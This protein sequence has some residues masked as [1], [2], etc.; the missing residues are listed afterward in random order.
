MSSTTQWV[1]N[2]TEWIL[3]GTLGIDD[4][5]LGKGK[6]EYGVQAFT[7]AWKTVKTARKKAALNAL[8]AYYSTGARAW[9]HPN[10]KNRKNFQE[11]LKHVNTRVYA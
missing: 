8:E 9:T 6:K 1:L 11:A 3:V 5:V 4:M 10:P 7:H 2:E